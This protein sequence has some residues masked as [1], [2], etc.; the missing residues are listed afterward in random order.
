L[1]YRSWALTGLYAIPDT[2]H[3]LERAE[4]D[5]RQAA[6]TPNRHQ[7]R[8]LSTLSAVLE[9]EGKVAEA[10][11]AAEQSYEADAYLQ[12]ANT[13]MFRVFNTALDLKRFADA[14]RWCDR[15]RRAF[16]SDWTFLMCQLS[17]LGWSEPI[18]P[19]PKRAWT[20]LRQLDSVAPPDVVVWIR[21]EMT[22]MVA[23][24]LARAGLSDSAER[25]ITR[26]KASAP[27]DPQLPYYEAMARVRL[28]QP[29]AT[30]ELLHKLIERSPNLRNFL[31]SR[32]AFEH[33]WTD[34]R[35][36]NLL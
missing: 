15:G 29:E 12:D 30:A 22:M 7:A 4:R 18:H 27:P 23:T 14:Q 13:I 35:F 36:A 34:P 19:D 25:V 11:L 3:K 2:T 1:L 5:L 6:A 20:I 33:L 28:A 31:R 21:P 10:N 17:L 9:F 8:A 24:V 26:A 16:P 32:S